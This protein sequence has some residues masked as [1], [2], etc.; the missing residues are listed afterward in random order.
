VIEHSIDIILENSEL[1]LSASEASQ[2]LADARK[3]VEGA[4]NDLRQEVETLNN[5]LALEIRHNNPALTV[6]IGRDGKCVVRYRNSGNILSFTADPETRRF[7][8]GDNPFERRFRRYHGH[9]LDRGPEMLGEAISRFFKQ[10]YR[11]I[12]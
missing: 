10:H 6:M 3:V 5:R 7:M 2:K 8:C 9:M 4:E 12:K 11:S 1:F